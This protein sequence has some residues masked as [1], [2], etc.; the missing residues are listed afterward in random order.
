MEKIDLSGFVNSDLEVISSF[1]DNNNV[2]NY[3]EN[4]NTEIEEFEMDLPAEASETQSLPLEDEGFFEEIEQWFEDVGAYISPML[5]QIYNFF[6]DTDYTFDHGREND[7]VIE[8]YRSGLT[9]E[10]IILES[11]RRAQT[12]SI[13]EQKKLENYNYNLLLLNGYTEEEAAN[14]VTRINAEV[15]YTFDYEKEYQIAQNLYGSGF[16]LEQI[17]SDSA[18]RATYASIEEQRNL[19]DFNYELLLACGYSEE[20]AGDIIDK[21]YAGVLNERGMSTVY[22]DD[23][24]VRFNVINDI[25]WENQA[26]TI[27]YIKEQ[28]A[29]LPQEVRKNIKEI[30]LY[31]TSNPCDKYWNHTYGSD[32][33]YFRSAATGGNGIITL[34]ANTSTSINTIFHEAGHCLDANHELSNSEAY[35]RAMMKDFEYNGLTAITEY[36]KNSLAE[37]FAEALA[38]YISGEN[39]GANIKDFPNRKAYFDEL[40]GVTT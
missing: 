4:I 21:I 32:N 38:A 29:R 13:E 16:T 24:G 28:I 39:R 14:T 35:Q 2:D 6:S 40:F 27:E 33:G 3:V 15:N 34:W 36:G 30:N 11:T 8:L 1:S 25:N 19:E 5:Y 31:D 20:E 23:A 10:Q 17:I 26:Y 12:G 37:D 18:R 9:L 7:N 22:I